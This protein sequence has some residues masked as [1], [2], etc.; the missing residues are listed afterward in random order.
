MLLSDMGADIL[1]I[2]RPSGVA[3]TGPNPVLQR[4]RSSILLDL[5][6]QDGLARAKEACAIADVVIE[7]NRPGVIERLV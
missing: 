5:K 2:D 4:G 7:G 6:T 1:R 3:G